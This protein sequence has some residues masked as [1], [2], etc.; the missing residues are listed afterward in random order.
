MISP[1]INKNPE[2]SRGTR[3]KDSQGIQN[4]A[5]GRFASSL[6]TFRYA[7]TCHQSEICLRYRSA[8]RQA[9]GGGRCLGVRSRQIP[10]VSYLKAACVLEPSPGPCREVCTPATVSLVNLQETLWDWLCVHTRWSQSAK[11]MNRSY[12][13]LTGGWWQGQGRE[14]V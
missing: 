11:V 1:E 14:G 2:F 9:A 13:K 6:L 5:S 3:K 12:S 4:V 10:E 7:G 8:R